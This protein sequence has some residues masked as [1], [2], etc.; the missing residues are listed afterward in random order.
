[1]SPEYVGKLDG[2]EAEQ[3]PAPCA[4]V[5]TRLPAGEQSPMLVS[6]GPIYR[7]EISGRDIV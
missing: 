5:N 7:T 4:E 2:I 6:V 3:H 1:M